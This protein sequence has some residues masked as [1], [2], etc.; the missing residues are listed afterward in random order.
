[1]G[2]GGDFLDEWR[3]MNVPIK[4]RHARMEEGIRIVRKLFSEDNVTFKGEF[5]EFENVT[6]EPKPDRPPPIWIAANPH[7]ANVGPKTI[8][9]VEQRIAR[10]ADGWMTTFMSPNMLRDAWTSLAET[11]R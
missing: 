3:A 4:S 9:K 2:G 1:M 8:K 10:L 6:V 7:T 11:L 5:Y